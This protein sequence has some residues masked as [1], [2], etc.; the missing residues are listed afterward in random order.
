MLSIKT[1][2]PLRNYNFKENLGKINYLKKKQGKN[3]KTTV[4][5]EIYP[6]DHCHKVKYVNNQQQIINSFEFQSIVFNA[7]VL[8]VGN[9]LSKLIN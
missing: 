7:G 8:G 9:N 2:I 4:I 6:Q 5:E 1:S 3:I